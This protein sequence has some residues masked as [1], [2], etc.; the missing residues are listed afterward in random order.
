MRIKHSKFRNTGLIF[1][2]LVKQIAADTLSNRDSSA[3]KILRKHF[4]GKTSLVKE[5]KMYEFIGKNKGVSQVK[6]DAIVSTIIE[7]SRRLNQNSLKKQK[8]ELIADIK[9]AYNIDEFFAMS[10]R[11]YKPLAALYCLMEAQNNADIVDPQILVNNKTTVLEHLTSLKQN[12]KDVKDNLIEEY[13]KYDKDVRLLTMKIM[14]ERFNANY[15]EL[16]PEQKRILKEFITSGNSNVRLMS[17]VNEEL[18]IIIENVTKL[19]K[20]VKDDVVRIKLEEISKSIVP[21]SKK[22]KVNDSHLI[23]LM[24]YYSLVAELKTL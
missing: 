4:T 5:Y 3:V 19:S 16:L 21:I 24:Q 11:D 10:V 12:E 7:I 8:Y 20:K 9:E 14:L 23:T 15:K 17:L 22:E 13:S 1:E 2:L 6:A 18:Q